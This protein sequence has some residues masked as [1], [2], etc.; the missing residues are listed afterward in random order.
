MRRNVIIV[1]VVALVLL[2][3]CVILVVGG[4]Y[5]YK[6]GRIFL[7]AA[8]TSPPTATTAP[9]PTK[10]P[11]ARPTP[12]LAARPGRL[13][14]GPITFASGATSD[15]KPVN[16]AEAFPAGTKQVYAFFD[17][18]GMTDDAP[19]SYVF[20]R[21]GKE[22]LS[23]SLD[24]TGGAEGNFWVNVSDDE[25]L[26][27]GN[28]E[29]RLLV[30]GRELQRGRFVIQ[31]GKP[32]VTTPVGKDPTRLSWQVSAPRQPVGTDVSVELGLRNKFGQPEERYQVTCRVT[33]PDGN[34]ALADFAVE[35]DNWTYLRSP[36]DFDSGDTRLKGAYQVVYLV[37]DVVIARDSFTVQ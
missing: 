18:S 31:A 1:I 28:Y 33:D 37:N 8:P 34:E 29:L 36:E 21:D 13:A 17:Y 26:A 25:G 14:F 12:T 16:P 22:V 11:P 24:W 32:G 2:C 6:S 23:K 9:I 35:G 4:F 7:T 10:A 27:S 5:A 30:S 3:C 15:D 19:W 20:Y